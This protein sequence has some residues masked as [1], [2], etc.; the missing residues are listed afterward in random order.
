MSNFMDGVKIKFGVAKAW[1]MSHAPTIF[2]VVGAIGVIAGTVTACIQTKNMS[3]IL[4]ERDK[5][6]DLIDEQYDNEKLGD[7]EYR[8]MVRHEYICWALRI[9][10]NYAIPAA[11]EILGLG[12]IFKGHG[13]LLTSCASLSTLLTEALNR[14]KALEDRIRDEYGEDALERLKYGEPCIMWKDDGDGDQQTSYIYDDRTDW[15][16]IWKPGM[17]E[18]SST[19]EEWNDRVRRTVQ[20]WVAKSQQLYG[21]YAQINDIYRRFGAFD[22]IRSEYDEACIGY[23]NLKLSD[24]KCKIEFIPIPGTTSKKKTC[25]DYRVHFINKPIPCKDMN[26]EARFQVS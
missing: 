16:F 14:E 9:G 8:S 15:D 7:R 13:M 6:L 4:E 18:Y 26:I 24:Y 17:G 20:L 3:D 12:L 19:D 1:G 22:K 21:S 5:K 2:T 25:P 10:K 23:P 11:I